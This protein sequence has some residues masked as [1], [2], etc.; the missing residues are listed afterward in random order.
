MGVLATRLKFGSLAVAV[1]VGL[2]W[3]DRALLPY[4][5]TG[6]AV[7]LFALGA[8]WELY[9]MLDQ[10]GLRPHIR[11]GLLAGG[12]YLFTRIAPMGEWLLSRGTPA[13]DPQSTYD[14]GAHLAVAVVFLLVAGVLSRR[15]EDAPRRIGSTLAGLL[16]V[17]FLLGYLIEIRFYHGWAWL[18]F[19]VAVAKSGDSAAFFAGRYLGK[20]KLIPE[21]SPNKTWEGALGSL[22][23]SL[24]AAW[25]VVT[26]A[27]VEPPSAALWVSAAVVTNIGA[28]F[29]D[30]GESLLKRGCAVKDSST[31]LPVMGGAF[32]MVDSFLIAA[33]VLRVFLAFAPGPA[34]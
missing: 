21:V 32:D 19:L 28:Q 7:A 15:P 17:P 4:L 26:T 3:L 11:L 34:S 27:F 10:A 5:T 33:P 20:H 31:L 22:A 25:I 24:L 9:K 23:G 30:L 6:V 16:V 2:F 1:V 29:G 14:A 18:V 8:Q 13:P 12:Y